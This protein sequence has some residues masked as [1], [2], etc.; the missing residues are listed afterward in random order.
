MR[1]IYI[2]ILL[3]LLLC[4]PVPA[5]GSVVVNEVEL[6]YL[7]ND[8][9][10][11]WVELYNDGPAEIDVSG[12]AIISRDDQSRK[13]SVPDGTVIP[14]GGFYQLSFSEKWIN[15]FGAVVILVNDND[16]EVDRTISLYDSQKDTCA[17][18]RYPDGGPE[19]QFME[20]TPGEANSGVPCEEVESKVL[21]FN[22]NGGVS[23][24]GFVNLQDR[25][26][27]P[28]G[29][30]VRSHEHGSGDYRSGASIKMDLNLISNKSTVQLRKDDLSM[31]HNRTV[32]ELPG[33]RTTIYDSKWAE[34]SA[35]DARNEGGESG[36]RA[37]Q[38]TTYASSVSK[39]LLAR[40]DYGSSALNLSTDSIGRTNIEYCSEDLKLSEVYLGA[41]HI[42]EVISE[43]DYQR[44]VNSTGESV[45]VDVYKKAKGGYSTYERGSGIYQADEL[46]EGGSSARKDLSLVYLPSSYAYFPRTVV[47]RSLKWDEGLK[48][49]TSNGLYAEES[50]SGLERMEKDVQ[51]NWPN[52]LQT[53]SSF[54][55]KANLR[56]VFRPDNNSTNLAVVED[57]YLGNYSIERK[58]TIMPKYTTPHM[59]VYK[60]GYIDP[61]RC[62]V[63]RFTVTVVND[64]NR[65][66]AP[67]YV[68]DTFPSGTRFIGSSIEPIELTRSYGNWSI[69]SLG[70]GE[71]ASI[72][73]QF[74]VITRREN[75]TNRARAN[76]IYVYSSRGTLRERNLRVSNST[77]LDVDWS[78]CPPEKLPLDFSA[79]VSQDGE[80]I[81]NYRLILNNSAGYNM[82][83]NITALLPEGMKFINSTTATLENQSGT[84]KWNIKKLDSGRR[85]TI[86]FMARAERDGIFEVDALVEGKSLEGNDSISASTSALIRV[87]KAPRATNIESIQ[88]MQWLSCDDSSM[89]Q[90]LAKLEATT[91]SKELKCC[92]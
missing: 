15:N 53:Y 61:D 33:N 17:W 38:S 50:Y 35:I 85:R 5:G 51:V 32:N 77:T 58:I 40:S 11:Q 16:L 42:D 14:P 64:G 57:E 23:G 66:F 6:D 74:K 60:Q 22:M 34:S 47:N 8:V 88:S 46:I 89:Y 68:R 18:G 39:E 25:V 83:A 13:E 44:T 78:S 1:P 75:Y 2:L 86:S 19:W 30:S 20:S 82:S 27:G 3:A 90:S 63:L 37:A 45:Y 73:M 80:K 55:G 81:V 84:I 91:S 28:D 54:T 69:P 72:D 43:N 36:S 92:Y 41:F 52:E 26:V 49:N 76:T 71:S 79:T 21:R 48:L 65:T 56:S 67:I 62:D 7:E 87:G 4:L 29:S 24:R 31:R 9:E 59:S 70:S 12:W 10:V